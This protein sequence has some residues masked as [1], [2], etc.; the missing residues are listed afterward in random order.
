MAGS[1]WFATDLSVYPQK[2][3]KHPVTSLK[4][5]RGGLSVSEAEM[6]QLSHL[7]SL[8]VMV[9]TS[10]VCH[11]LFCT[12]SHLPSLLRPQMSSIFSLTPAM[13]KNVSY[14]GLME[15][16]TCKEPCVMAGTT[17]WRSKPCAWCRIDP[18]VLIDALWVH[19]NSL[20]RSCHSQLTES[21]PMC[22]HHMLRGTER[23][24]YQTRCYQGCWRPTCFLTPFSCSVDWTLAPSVIYYSCLTQV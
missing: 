20:V 19:R 18:A 2:V 7:S 15:S 6:C 14:R 23:V 3:D 8:A 11:L 1:K 21:E 5:S 9:T 13:I 12:K 4:P 24:W 22:R 17:H 10:P 16:P